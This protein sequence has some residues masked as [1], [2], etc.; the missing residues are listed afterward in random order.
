M[1]SRKI[2]SG[3][4]LLAKSFSPVLSGRPQTIHDNERDAASP[5]EQTS[6]AAAQPVTRTR[7]FGNLPA[8]VL[9][10]AILLLFLVVGEASA[11]LYCN[12][13][14]TQLKRNP[15]R[16]YNAVGFLNNGCTAFLI[17]SKHIAA[18]A[19]CFEDTG[20]GQWQTGLRFYPNFHPSRVRQDEMH[21]PRANV[22][23]IVVGSRAGENVLG[24]GMDWGIA[25]LGGWQ[26][27]AG[28][29]LTPVALA[30]AMPSP[31]APLANPAYTRHHF[32]YNDN[33]PPKWDNMVWDTTNC[34]WVQPNNGAW[35]VRMRPAPIYDGVNRDMVGCNSRWSAGYIHAD[36]SLGKI[37]DDVVVHNCDT[38]GGSSGSPIMRLDAQGNW[39]VIAVGHGGGSSATAS[40]NN[41]ALLTPLC[42]P[43]IPSNSDNI[44]ASVERFRDAPRYASNVAVHRS[45]VS[46]SAT[47]VFAVDSDSDTVVYRNRLGSTPTYTSDFTY[48]RSLGTPFQGAKL[49][50][51]AACAAGANGRPQVF[52]TVNKN[53]IYT[54]SADGL[55]QWSG[56]SS[57]G[58]PAKADS[59]GDL[60]A[61]TDA[62]GRCL[63]FMVARGGK[64]YVRAKTSD[65]TWEGWKKVTGGTYK[66]LTAI[67]YAGTIWVALLDTTGEI[68][69]VSKGVAGWTSR[70]KLPRPAQISAWRDIDLTWDELARGFM[71][72]IPASW[73][74]VVPGP[75]NS[76]WFTPLYGSQPWN[77]WRTFETHLWAPG[78]APQNPPKL[79]SITASRW[80]ED[81]PGTTSPVIFG[82]D[83]N[84]NV[85]MVE[86]AR[87]APVGWNLN[88]KSFYHKNIPY[89]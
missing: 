19:H 67:N 26:D 57:F 84:G 73:N 89:P 10:S 72:A 85:Y 31:G 1:F 8:V 33:A 18:A 27:A 28:L 4:C 34:G 83:D 29:D 76:L 17:D 16:P 39:G 24:A 66:A 46:T 2:S 74:G 21:V 42:S 44:G 81:P 55:G 70:I 68:W 51:I 86:Y 32:P 88:W 50:R 53:M 6:L 22:K 5:T 82:T 48:W 20:T 54:R 12:R 13:P 35:A 11:T 41:F 87:V 64:A 47:A 15:P 71:L 49:G 65:T 36:C 52:V 63:L 59:V 60:D 30:N 9:G 37:V 43:D 69:R 23:R 58:L 3:W 14:Y 40:S 78:V 62:N 75:T 25:R 56:W 45:P 77:E 61:A 38:I 7:I 80:M 79:Q